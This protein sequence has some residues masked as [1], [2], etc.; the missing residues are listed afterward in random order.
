MGSAP[1]MGSRVLDQAAAGLPF[2][3]LVG[4]GEIYHGISSFSVRPRGDRASINIVSR[5][6]P[7]YSGEGAGL[8]SPGPALIP[9]M[10]HPHSVDN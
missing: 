5:D 4:V 7:A 9:Q 8:L 2:W 1:V 6:L 3:F 10:P